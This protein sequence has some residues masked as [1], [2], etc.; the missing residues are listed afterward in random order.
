MVSGSVITDISERLTSQIQGDKNFIL[1]SDVL[2]IIPME[3][4]PYYLSHINKWLVSSHPIYLPLAS[5]HDENV[6]FPS[7][8]LFKIL[9]QI[10]GGVRYLINVWSSAL[11]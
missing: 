5:S 4:Q 7:Q 6:F 2:N 8:C 1:G 10:E 3:L 11:H 9:P